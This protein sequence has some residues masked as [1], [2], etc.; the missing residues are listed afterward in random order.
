MMV[1]LRNFVKRFNEILKTDLH[2]LY[3]KISQ[4]EE[5]PRNMQQAD[6]FS[7]KEKGDREDITNWRPISLLNYDNK[8]YT[9]I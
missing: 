9:K 1:Y 7:L 8:I 6:I 3:I 5:M 2:K 4:L